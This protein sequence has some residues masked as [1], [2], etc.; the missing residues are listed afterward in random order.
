MFIKKITVFVFAFLFAA[1]WLFA[2]QRTLKLSPAEVKSYKQQCSQM[3]EYLTSTLNF[4]GDPNNPPSEKEIIINSSYL[5]IFR[6]EKVQIEDDLAHRQVPLNK[7]VQAYLKDVVFFFKQ[8]HFSTHIN[9]IDALVNPQG[10]IYF[11]VSLI[12]T[13]QGITVNNDTVDNDEPRY[14]EINLNQ[15]KNDLKIASIY[16]HKPNENSEL[17]YWW[18]NLSQ[19]WKDYFG[20]S[21]LVYDTLPLRKVIWFSHDSLITV[22]KVPVSDSLNSSDSLQMQQN[23]NAADSTILINDTG[24]QQEPDTILVNTQLLFQVLHYVKRNRN[25]DV[26]GNLN[27]DNLEPLSE[28]PDL[29]SVDVSHTLIDDLTPLRS[30]NKLE[31]LNISGCPVKSLEPMRYASG[32][33]ELD[34]SYTMITKMEVLGNLRNLESVN[35]SYSPVDSLKNISGLIHLKVLNLAGTRIQQIDSLA[36]LSYL[37]SLDLARD[38][39][40]SYEVLASL[41]GLQNL[42]LDSSNVTDLRPLAHLN[43]LSVLHI[44]NTKVKDIMPLA[45]LKNLKYIYCDNSG[46]GQKEAELFAEKNPECQV[47][48]NSQELE[49]WWNKLP[50]A[51]KDVFIK[52]LPNKDTITKEE[53]HLLLQLDTLNL[54]GNKN[55][56]DLAPLSMLSQ[57]TRLNVSGTSITGVAP[58]SAMGGLRELNISHTTV[59]SLQPLEKLRSL[60]L[61]NLNYTAVSD[62]MPLENNTNLVRIYADESNVKGP[63]VLA[64]RKKNPQTLVIFQS[65]YLHYWWNHLGSGWKEA[66]YKLGNL[67]SVPTNEQLQ[68]LVNREKLTLDYPGLRY[69]LEALQEFSSLSELSINNS[70]LVDIRGLEKIQTLRSVRFSNCPLADISTLALLKNLREINLEN[71]GVEDLDPLRNLRHLETLNLSGTRV[72][73]LNALEGIRSLQNLYINNTPIRR[74]K[75]IMNLPNIKLL[76]CDHTNI[77]RKQVDEF[78]QMHQGAQVVFY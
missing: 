36:G 5:K 59:S 47:I 52:F 45:G 54:S 50:S 68:Q 51:W 3:I 26:S 11:K 60:K 17:Q 65:P 18:N 44:S 49:T 58:L 64:F 57:L 63:D 1:Q 53:L 22:R 48:Y 78:K 46:I 35:L 70:N 77:G 41:G 20:Q 75:F 43:N 38:Q 42:D 71:T 16:T 56:H 15:E 9:S 29:V 2:E 72:K 13:L 25:V 14:I 4:L 69:G 34:A 40:K 23:S 55:I 21:I 32:L 31:T 19:G 66:F 73:V 12:R 33:R 39:V 74:L 10:K 27:I 61:I 37:A 62:L 7:D 30:L 8:V 28:L 24:Y 76:R 6:D 67:D